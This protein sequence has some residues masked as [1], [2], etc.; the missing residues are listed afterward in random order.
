MHFQYELI[1]FV[2]SC[3]LLRWNRL[4]LITS[5][6]ATHINRVL[7]DLFCEGIDYCLVSVPIHV[8]SA[9]MKIGGLPP[10]Y[11]LGRTYRVYS[12][13][14]MAEFYSAIVCRVKGLF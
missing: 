9:S 6:L 7:V 13:N 10:P 1:K 14:V 2:F 5:I 4:I 11:L 8:G 3:T 12:S